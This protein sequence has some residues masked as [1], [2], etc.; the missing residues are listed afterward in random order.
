M[1]E[2]LA[3]HGAHATADD[4]INLWLDVTDEQVAMVALAAHGIAVAPGR[5]FE[6]SR[7]DTDHVRV[8]VGLVSGD[9]DGFGVA[10][11]AGV[12]A[13][14]AGAPARAGSRP[15]HPLPRGGR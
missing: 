12:L 11:L 2:A 7:L 8:T 15:K 13:A 9:E 4:G 14:A 5:P 1:L 10:E 3:A 6:V